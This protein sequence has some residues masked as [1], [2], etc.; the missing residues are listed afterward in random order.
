MKYAVS[1]IALAVAGASAALA[2]TP[3]LNSNPVAPA[4]PAYVASLDLPSTTC[5]LQ[6]FEPR[7]VA[8]AN[9]AEA[10]SWTLAIDAPG[11]VNEQSGPVSGPHNRLKP[12]TRLMMGGIAYG[13]QVYGGS[14]SMPRPF[15]AELNVY[16]LDGE[17]VCRDVIDLP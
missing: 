16:D 17:L 1:A 4:P 5:D 15:Y 13:G 2:C 14:P 6:L 3:Q 9:P 11:F 12:V 10:S 8:L 7:L